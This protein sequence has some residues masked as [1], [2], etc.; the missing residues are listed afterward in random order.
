LQ[1]AAEAAPALAGG[2]VE[3]EGALGVGHGG[4]AWFSSLL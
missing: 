1:A 2:I 4:S 3:N